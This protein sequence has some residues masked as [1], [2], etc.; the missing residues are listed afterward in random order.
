MG[1]QE[2]VYQ[3]D[4]PYR[5]EAHM[6]IGDIVDTLPDCLARL[7]YQKIFNIGCKHRNS[8]PRVADNLSKISS[9]APQFASSE[10]SAY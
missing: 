5:L 4:V 2:P 1:G 3:S 7:L 9:R 8:T 10:Y 6:R